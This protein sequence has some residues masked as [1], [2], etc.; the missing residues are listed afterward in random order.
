MQCT[1][2]GQENPANASVCS[3]CNAPLP[4][5][6]LP[7]PE[8]GVGASYGYGWKQ[9]W[10]HFWMLLLIGIIVF[11]ISLVASLFTQGIS[12]LGGL[13]GIGAGVDVAIAITAISV[14]FS[15]AYSI[16][17]TNPLGYGVAFVYLKATRDDQV[18]VKDMFEAFRCYWDA[19]L[20]SLLVGLIVIVGIIFLIVPGIIFAC[21]LAFVPY[22]V[23]D[24]KIGA[25]D[26]IK[27]SWRMTGGYAWKVFLLYLLGIP[28]AIA[29]FICLGIGVIPA[30]M[31]INTALATLY[32]AVS[33]K[34]Q[35]AIQ[36]EASTGI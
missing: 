29:G 1:S 32:Y 18:E 5:T 28:I 9:L 10:K 23:I 21:K 19:V 14:V 4:L 2:C 31:W 34:G 17:L 24:R 20:A 15:L 30:S 36:P 27:E 22:L 6:Q 35:A 33:S 11:A 26:S 7:V 12:A 13:G 25:I 16:F 3:R 8:I